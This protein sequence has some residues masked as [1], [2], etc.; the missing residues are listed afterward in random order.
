MRQRKNFSVL[1]H[2]LNHSVGE[3]F[4]KAYY[5]LIALGNMNLTQGNSEATATEA[6][7]AALPL[8]ARW[9]DHQSKAIEAL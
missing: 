9:A 1:E 4:W 8:S 3:Y 2:K 7:R 6:A 5:S